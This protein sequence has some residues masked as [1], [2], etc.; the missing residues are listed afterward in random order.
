MITNN[1]ARELLY[2]WHSG[3]WSPLYAAAS[4]G[5]VLDIQKLAEGI[6]DITDLV[7]KAK[8]FKWFDNARQ[9]YPLEEVFGETYLKLPWRD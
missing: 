3:Q 9:N 8:L 1:E 7:D 4:S 5:L 6:N 2:A